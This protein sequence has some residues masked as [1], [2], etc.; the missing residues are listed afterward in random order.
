[1]AVNWRNPYAQQQG[2]WW[3]GNLHTHSRP[4]SPCAT[5]D[6]QALCAAYQRSGHDFV[7]LSEHMQVTAPEHD[8]LICLPGL[9]WNA[10]SPYMPHRALTYQHHLGAYSLDTARLEA[11]A[12][13]LNAEAFCAAAAAP[14][15]VLVANHPNWL[16]PEHYD[17]HALSRLSPFLDG[18]EIYNAILEKDEGEAD[19]TGRWDRLLSEGHPL[20]GFASDDSHKAADVGLAWLEVRAPEPS[21]Q[22]EMAGAILT[23]IKAGNF[24]CTTGALIMDI[25]RQGDTLRVRTLDEAQIRLRGT[26]GR[27]LAE[28]VGTEFSWTFP[29]TGEPYVRFEIMDRDWGRAWSQ[30]FFHQEPT[31]P[32]NGSRQ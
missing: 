10:R 24:Y 5:I 26:W 8:D 3:R 31:R 6:T 21:S 30:P 22:S 9:E 15:V 13:L 14:D 29:E 20:L 25:D 27:L 18:L 28:T 7:S 4:F 17:Q 1:M 16:A 11:T 32:Q 19:A 23:A 2:R 12:P